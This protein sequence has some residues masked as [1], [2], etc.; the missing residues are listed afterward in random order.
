MRDKSEPYNQLLLKTK[1]NELI[2]I[3]ELKLKELITHLPLNITNELIN[4]EKKNIEDI[5]D[6]IDKSHRKLVMIVERKFGKERDY[7]NQ[8]KSIQNMPIG[9]GIYSVDML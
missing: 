7:L 5:E 3:N 4:L 2:G 8:L 9:P 6:I 1:F